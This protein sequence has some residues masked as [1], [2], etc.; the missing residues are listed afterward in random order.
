M[1]GQNYIKEKDLGD[2]FPKEISPEIKKLILEQIEK[3]ICKIKC[4]NG[5]NGTGFFC[6]IP[7]KDGNLFRVFI[8]NNYILEENDIITGNLISIS[9]NNDKINRE[10][11]MD[12]LREK[13]TNKKY[14]ITIIEIRPNDGINADSFLELDDDIFKDNSKELSNKRDIYLLYYNKSESTY[15][16]GKIKSINEDNYT[17][18]HLCESTGGSSGGP[19]INLNNFKVIGINK[20]DKEEKYNYVIYI[21][22]P[23]EE[24][25][26]N[27][28][29]NSKINLDISDNKSSDE[30][31]PKIDY[32]NCL[33]NVAC[34]I[35]KYFDIPQRHKTLPEVDKLFKE[36]TPEN[37]ILILCDGLGSRV[38]D[39]I[40]KKDD[41]L[42]K[43]REKEIY[44]TFPPTTAAGLTSIKTG[45]N[46][47]EHGW[48]GW[49]TYIKEINKIVKI[50]KDKDKDATISNNSKF[51]KIKK[52]VLSP[53]TIVDQIN[54]A[55]KY[56]A[57]ETNCYPHNE[58]S[59]ID[60]VFKNILDKLKIKG[61]K[62]IF[63]YIGEPDHILHSKG[64]YS[65]Q[66]KI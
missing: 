43:K 31:K 23:I 59:N 11:K 4:K 13:Y 51:I 36:K 65:N 1:E 39:V 62:Y 57:F 42:M 26:K 2:E 50:Y 60:K 64:T 37:V 9:L 8:T 3:S 58:E 34:S 29:E 48:I 18:L 30:F 33:T 40:L 10:I 14:D 15:S 28:K 27:I 7:K 6:N 22:E 32:N 17:I 46:P 24:F 25:I 61:K 12:E 5:G 19:L 38:M 53:K 44:S 52:K 41:Y 55:G 56:K 20:G 49:F 21:K 16:F 35:Q 54:E 47:S 66:A 63:S 45:L